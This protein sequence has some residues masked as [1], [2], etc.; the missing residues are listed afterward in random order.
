MRLGKNVIKSSSGISVKRIAG[1]DGVYGFIRLF[2]DKELKSQNQNKSVSC[3]KYESMKYL[4]ALLI[5][6]AFMQTGCLHKTPKTPDQILEEGGKNPA[7]NA[8]AGKYTFT[9]PEGWRRLDTTMQHVR[10][11]YLFAPVD[12]KASF[13]PNINITTEDMRGLSLDE[14]FDKNVAAIGQYMQHFS[15][16]TASARATNGNKLKI[17]EYTH[18]MNGVDMDVTMAVIPKD[19]IAYVITITVPKDHRADYQKAFDTVVNSFSIS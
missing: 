2:T 8:G 4:Y 11:T 10:F 15:A 6:G 13:H 18:T 1:Y 7:I 14:Y 19:G 12:P 3:S 17:Q 9:A 5:A 16:G